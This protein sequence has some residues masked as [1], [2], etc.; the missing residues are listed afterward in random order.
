MDPRELLT[1]KIGPLPAWGWGV[2]IGGLGLAFKMT[3]G[4]G[5]QQRETLVVPTGGSGLPSGD[6]IGQFDEELAASRARLDALEQ[7]SNNNTS[8]ANVGS[9]VIGWKNMPVGFDLVTW[10]R[11]LRLKF[12]KVARRAVVD[13]P[14][15]ETPAQRQRR[16]IKELGAY[17]VA[18]GSFDLA[19]YVRGLRARFPDIY[20]T[21]TN[22][23]F[24]GET[25]QQRIARLWDE[26]AHYGQFGKTAIQPPPITPPASGNSVP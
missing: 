21:V 4:G 5:G 11:G 16:L 9:P 17:G 6:F 3:R 20:A 19:T 12:P 15:G 24:A 26:I 14:K 8:G 23:G 18:G 1:R 22:R 2:A 10:I 25:P 7:R 13:A